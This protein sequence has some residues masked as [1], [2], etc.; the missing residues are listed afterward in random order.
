MNAIKNIYFTNF[1][2]RTILKA[3]NENTDNTDVRFIYNENE[4]N[5]PIL[6]SSNNIKC[7]I[8]KDFRTCPG[9]MGVIELKKPIF[10]PLYIDTIKMVLE[11]ICPYHGILIKYNNKTCS[12][13]NCTYKMSSYELKDVS[14]EI[15]F[16]GKTNKLIFKP[17]DVY[18]I[19]KKISKKDVSKLGFNVLHNTYPSDLI[20]NYIPV[21]PNYIR[22]NGL[23]IDNIE[24]EE[25]LNNISNFKYVYEKY[26]DIVDR[27]IDEK[28]TY[29][30]LI[31]RISGKDGV[32]RKNIY[33]KR[34]GYCGRTVIVPN[35]FLKV[36]MVGIPLQI[37]LKLNIKNN[38][39]VIV[40]RHPTIYRSSIMTLRVKIIYNNK[41]ISLN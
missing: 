29:K 6:G 22:P 40:L 5:S 24:T 23:T 11:S 19:F 12:I 4:I 34:I 13:H 10:H 14:N 30:S 35:P 27:P 28:K 41:A 39:Y 16:V 18:S 38:D 15:C 9:H 31:Q 7:N 8:C 21:I 20:L 37:A 3:Y 25:I 32:S 17:N 2:K 36:D 26:K 1:T 33:S